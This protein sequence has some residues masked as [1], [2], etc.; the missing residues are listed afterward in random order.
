[1][2]YLTQLHYAF[3][4]PETSATIRQHAEDFQ[5]REQ[6]SF[7]P[8]GEGQHVYLFIEKRDLNTDD[9][10]QQ[11]ARFADVRQVAVGYAGLKDRHAITTQWFSVDLAGQAEPDWTS[12]NSNNINVIEAVRHS[13]KLKRGAVRSNHFCI[14]LRDFSGDTEELERRL[15]LIQHQGVPNYFGEQRFGRHDA[16]LKQAE[17]LFLQ[18]KESVRKKRIKRHLRG[19]YLSAVRAFLFNQVLSHR[20]AD[21]TWNQ[22]VSGDVFMLDGSHS[23]FTVETID[24]EIIRRVHEFDIHPTAPMWGSGLSLATGDAFAVETETLRAHQ[25]WCDVLENAGMKQER[26]ALRL[27]VEELDWAWQ[28]SDVVL[29]F[30]LASGSYATSVLRELVSYD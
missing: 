30:S 1:M 24:G 27:K 22:P 6:L 17:K 25:T 19:I 3:G 5:V 12:M 28:G 7:N 4:K 15:E 26:R 14:V 16:N 20:V 2:S 29:R 8:A 10:A 9:V 11:L 18:S 23:I 13:R 21:K